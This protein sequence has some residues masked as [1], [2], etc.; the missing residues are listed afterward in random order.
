MRYCSLC[1][2]ATVKLPCRIH[3]LAPNRNMENVDNLGAQSCSALGTAVQIPV[4]GSGSQNASVS[5]PAWQLFSEL[6]REHQ[7]Y[8]YT[9]HFTP[10]VAGEIFCT[11]CLLIIP[12][13]E[14]ALAG[15]G[16][17]FTL[18]S[19]AWPVRI[20]PINFISCILVINQILADAAW[21]IL[22]CWCYRL[23]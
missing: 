22:F 21:S 4:G 12:S 3:V 1:P 17:F 19:V 8:K 20:L 9:V 5:A 7:W 16:L 23:P 13:N 14:D 15:P 18:F 2:S 11:G 10:D 6:S